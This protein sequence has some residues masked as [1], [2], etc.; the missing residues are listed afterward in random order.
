M[1][2]NEAAVLAIDYASLAAQQVGTSTL[3]TAANV[4][5]QLAVAYATLALY[6]KQTP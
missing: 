3:T 5:A 2:P 1:S 4:N 6:L